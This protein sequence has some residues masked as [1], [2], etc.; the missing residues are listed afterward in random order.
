[1]QF[2]HVSNRAWLL[3]G[4]AF[5]GHVSPDC[6]HRKTAEKTFTAL[7]GAV[8]L[9]GWRGAAGAGRV[10][11]VCRARAAAGVCI[12]AGAGFAVGH[13]RW[14]SVSPA[15]QGNGGVMLGSNAA[16][17]PPQVGGADIT[18]LVAASV[19]TPSLLPPC[20]QVTAPIALSADITGFKTAPLTACLLAGGGA[21]G[22]PAARRLRGRQRGRHFREHVAPGGGG[23]QPCNLG[24]AFRESVCEGFGRFA[25]LM[26]QYR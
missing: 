25:W 6:R 7:S 12:P 22:G 20:C 21:A 8:P 14:G 4:M 2:P 26:T 15:A 10:H 16:N 13:R 5:A 17:S 23:R 9:C 18:R 11:R 19:R 3:P 1:M 24:P